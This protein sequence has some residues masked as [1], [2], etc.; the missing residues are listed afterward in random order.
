M[1][2]PGDKMTIGKRIKQ[3]RED[4]GLTQTALARAVGITPQTI[5]KYENEII[6][7][8]TLDKIEKMAAALGISPACL[9]GW[10]EAPSSEVLLNK[11]EKL[12]SLGKE[13]ADKLIDSLLKDK[14]YTV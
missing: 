13:K 8:V 6:E 4:K 14:K 9:V 11:F 12:N 1:L 7:D 5:Y 2:K 10:D 3:I